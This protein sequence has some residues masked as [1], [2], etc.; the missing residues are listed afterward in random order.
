MRLMVRKIRHLVIAV[1]NNSPKCSFFRV[2]RWFD[3]TKFITEKKNSQQYVVIYT[4]ISCRV[5]ELE[6]EWDL[7][8]V[9]GFW[10]E[11]ESDS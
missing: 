10:V 2:A 3:F 11:S 4:E 6:P 7:Q 5:A 8:R 9:R 1:R